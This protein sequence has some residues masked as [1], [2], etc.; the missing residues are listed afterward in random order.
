LFDLFQAVLI[1][2]AHVF[3]LGSN[4][5]SVA[6]VLYAAAWISGEFSS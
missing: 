3:I 2:N 6:E 1:D 4:S 5:S